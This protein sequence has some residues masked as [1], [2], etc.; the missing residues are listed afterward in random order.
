MTRIKNLLEELPSLQVALPR[1]LKEF[2]LFPELPVELQN[3]IWQISIIKPR[4]VK[5]Y[6]ITSDALQTPQIE[7]QHAVP[8]ILHTSHS[9][10]DEGLRYYEACY[11]RTPR[12]K[13]SRKCGVE[14]TK[15]KQRRIIY[16]NFDLDQFVFDPQ[17]TQGLQPLRREYEIH[18]LNFNFEY[19]LICRIKHV[20]FTGFPKPFKMLQALLRMKGVDYLTI[21]E[22]E[23]T[24]ERKSESF[25]GYLARIYRQEKLFSWIPSSYLQA[26]EA[27]QVY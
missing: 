24:S 7:G 2:T 23:W 26:R 21:L 16:I 15:I 27:P 19:P 9:A 13:C 14:H 18:P 11:E 8:A 25:H 10:R 5:I 1:P 12:R 6:D 20:A 4:S 3:R 17:R 22:E